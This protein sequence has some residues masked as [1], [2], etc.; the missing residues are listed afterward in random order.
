MSTGATYLSYGRETIFEQ[1]YNFHIWRGAFA[2]EDLQ[3]VDNHTVLLSGLRK[4]TTYAYQAISADAAGNRTVS[5]VG[6]F[7]YN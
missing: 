2:A 4:R 6:S 5:P 7:T 1:Y 3:F